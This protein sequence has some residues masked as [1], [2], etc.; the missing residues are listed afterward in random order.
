MGTVVDSKCGKC[1]YAVTF[2]LGNGIMDFRLETA[3]YKFRSDKSVQHWLKIRKP[4][5]F[6]STNQAGFCKKCNL[7]TTASVLTLVDSAGLSRKF[8]SHCNECD[9]ILSTSSENETVFCP[10]CHLPLSKQIIGNWD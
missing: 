1:D 5:S 10:K 3:L 7:H 9:S 6:E 2:F 8:I 4:I